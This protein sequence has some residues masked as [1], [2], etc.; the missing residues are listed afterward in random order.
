MARV[1]GSSG[2]YVLSWL[3]LRTMKLLSMDLDEVVGFVLRFRLV[4][5]RSRSPYDSIDMWAP[6]RRRA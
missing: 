3:S 1:W 2:L 6:I 5:I 4:M